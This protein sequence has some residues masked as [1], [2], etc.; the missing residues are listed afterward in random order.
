MSIGSDGPN[1][2]KKIWNRVVQHLKSNGLQGLVEFTPCALHVVHNAFRK[3]IYVF[4]EDVEGLAVAL[5]QWFKSY[6]CQ[7]EKKLRKH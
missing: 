3:G 1:V 7:K 6:P 4:G 2:N 5:F